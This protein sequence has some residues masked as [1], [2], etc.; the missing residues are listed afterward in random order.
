MCYDG[1]LVMPSN[2]AVMYEDEMIYVD[3]GITV[4]GVCAIIGA[5]IAVGGATYGAGQVCG[6]R[7][8]YAGVNTSKKWKK[9]KWA[10]RA[11]AISL[12]PALGSIFMIGLENK[13]Y[14]MM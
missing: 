7:L 6:E 8:Y 10:A 14:S 12:Q 9:Y 11:T 13:L 4:E 3:G 1:A 5:V 2:Y